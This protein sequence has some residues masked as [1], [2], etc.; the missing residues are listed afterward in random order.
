[1]DILDKFV[2][3]AREN[4]RNGHYNLSS[5]VKLNKKRVSLKQ[6]LLTQSFTLIAEIKHASP[7]GEYSFDYIDV[8]KAAFSFKDAGAD[9][10]SVVV[11]PKIFKGHLNNILVAKKTSLPVL[12]KDFIISETQ[13]R[14]AATLGADCILLIVKVAERINLDLNKLIKTA[15]SYGLEVLLECYNKKEIQKAMKTKA[16][17]IGINNRDL[18]TLKVNLNR[19]KEIMESFNETNT[20]NRPVISESGIKSRKDAE[21]VKSTGVNGILVGTALWTTKDQY[22]KI[23]ELGL[24]D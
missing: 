12:F 8:E 14:T 5:E 18:Q 21:F 13:I 15:H 3:Q 20:L 16:D 23:K 2:E 10:I 24:C 6:K 1:M 11:E 7:A 4:I 19:T 17:I 9:A 22:A